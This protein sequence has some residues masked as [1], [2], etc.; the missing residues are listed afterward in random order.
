MSTITTAA[1]LA[2]LPVGSIV[3]RFYG[4]GTVPSVYV[5][6]RPGILSD[7]LASTEPIDPRVGGGE[8]L[9]VLYRPDTPQR[10]AP[11]VE[12]VAQ[13]IRHLVD[14]R[15]TYQPDCESA[16][17]AVLALFDAVPT[18]AEIKARALREAA[19]ELGNS[20]SAHRKFWADWLRQ[21]AE[22]VERGE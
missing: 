1:E 12:E 3:A 18:V 2:A 5:R 17:R 4:E 16:A 19:E 13:T 21:R 10:A 8:P 20:W 14:L 6:N 9:T 15:W 11:S 22:R 7:W